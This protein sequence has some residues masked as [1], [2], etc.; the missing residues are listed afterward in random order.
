MFANLS[1]ALDTGQLIESFQL[2]RRLRNQYG[3]TIRHGM[4]CGVNG[5]AWPLVDLGIQGFSLA[6]NTHVGGAPLQ[7]PGVFW[8]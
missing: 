7:R 1:L 4:S 5:E 6:I 8:W 2:L 3:F